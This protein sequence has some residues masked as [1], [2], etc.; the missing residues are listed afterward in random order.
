MKRSSQNVVESTENGE[1]STLKLE[2]SPEKMEESNEKVEECLQIGDESAHKVEEN[3]SKEEGSLK[4]TEG[5]LTCIFKETI[6]DAETMKNEFKGE[7]VLKGDDMSFK[8]S[9]DHMV[10]EIGQLKNNNKELIET[11]IK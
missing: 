8:D 6:D 1:E 7:E 10:S 2:E 9:E 5:S 3:P 4:K 11:L